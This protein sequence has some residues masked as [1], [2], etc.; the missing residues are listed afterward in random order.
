ML[1]VSRLSFASSKNALM[2]MASGQS[3]QATYGVTTTPHFILLGADGAL[4][5][6]HVGWGPETRQAL[7]TLI[8][9]ELAK[10]RR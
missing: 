9:Q 7:Q 8:R 6:S 10:T 2:L 1:A 5:A 4:L 3:L